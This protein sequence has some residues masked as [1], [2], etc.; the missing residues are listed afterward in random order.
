MTAG[1]EREIGNR[2]AQPGPGAGAELPEPVQRLAA[3]RGLGQPV[4]VRRELSMT[5]ALVKGVVG[6]V[7]GLALMMLL[8]WLAGDAARGSSVVTAIAR[9]FAILGLGALVWG[10][11]MIVRGL[12]VGSRAHYLFAGGLVAKRRTGLI[13][14]AWPQIEQLESRYNRK[15]RDLVGYR[16]HAAGGVTFMI[17]LVLTNNRDAFIDRIADQLRA[18]GRPVR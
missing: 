9:P 17:P 6:I 1:S 8:G 12:L 2:D 7:G 4:D 3:E 14:V 16:V 18:H 13:A 5:G 10:I 11:V 15:T